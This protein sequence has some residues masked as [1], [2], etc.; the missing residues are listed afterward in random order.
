MNGLKDPKKKKPGV[1]GKNPFGRGAGKNN[2]QEDDLENEG[3]ENNGEYSVNDG[4]IPGS[5]QT[6]SDPRSVRN[7][8]MGPPPVAFQTKQQCGI[9]NGR[10]DLHHVNTNQKQPMHLDSSQR[11]LIRTE[12]G[13][14]EPPSYKSPNSTVHQY[15]TNDDRCELALGDRLGVTGMGLSFSFSHLNSAR[16][17][18][19]NT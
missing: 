3:G 12:S 10:T 5:N 8:I 14:M 19:H 16:L 6:V 9:N 18:K 1:Q 4:I 15:M 11:Q 7:V 13:L 17:Q 2:T